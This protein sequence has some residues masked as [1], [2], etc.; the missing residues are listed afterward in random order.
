MM[1][2]LGSYEKSDTA[3]RELT[4]LVQNRST[5]AVTG[6]GISVASGLPILSQE[7]QGIP[8]SQLFEKDLWTKNPFKAYEVYREI[9][10]LWRRANPS[11]A[12][13]VL[14]YYDIP[15]ITQNIDGLHLDA[16][17]TKVIEIHGNLR[18]LKCHKCEGLF[19]S[20][21]SMHERVP[22]CP[23]CQNQLFPGFSLEGDPVR[24]MARAVEWVGAAEVLVI[25]G[26]KLSMYPIRQLREMAISQS[27]YV[28]W[29]ND[30]ADYW[31]PS[32]FGFEG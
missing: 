6:A 24:H 19:S 3:I 14:A 30:F 23:V 17:S 2:E 28:I 13:D 27:A 10:T 31:L 11:V 32:V 29:V 21:L 7:M 18:E 25:V 26:T 22:H 5:L 12:H 4:R 15:V 1:Y 16:G 20:D 9:L 8:I